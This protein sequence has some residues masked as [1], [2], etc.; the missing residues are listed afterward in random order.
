MASGD[1]AD[2][3]SGSPNDLGVSPVAFPDIEPSTL[4]PRSQ[5]IPQEYKEMAEPWLAVSES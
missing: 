2:T 5:P 1:G 3:F 4:L